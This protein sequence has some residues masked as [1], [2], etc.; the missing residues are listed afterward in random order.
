MASQKPNRGTQVMLEGLTGLTGLKQPSPFPVPE[1]RVAEEQQPS[2]NRQVL[3]KNV[4]KRKRSL[5]P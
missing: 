4:P 1:G 3:K 2:Q 5:S